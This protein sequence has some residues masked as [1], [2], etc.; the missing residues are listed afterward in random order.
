MR[1]FVAIPLPETVCQALSSAQA[2]L[3]NQGRGHLTAPQNL[4]L[5]L[6]FIGETSREQDAAAALSGIAFPSFEITVEGIDSFG[7]LYWA[8]VRPSAQLTELQQFVTQKLLDAGFLLEPRSFLPHITICRRYHASAVPDITAVQ[9]A[10]G[11][12]TFKVHHFHLMQSHHLSGILTYTPR[13]TVNL[14]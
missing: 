11:S 8:G 9:T 2:A 6:A 1:L 14:R 7:D 3:C 4:H 5:T 13:F 10:L 12:H